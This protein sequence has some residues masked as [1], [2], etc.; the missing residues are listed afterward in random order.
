MDGPHCI[1]FTARPLGTV[2]LNLARAQKHSS[3]HQFNHIVA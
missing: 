3:R 2:D 1:I